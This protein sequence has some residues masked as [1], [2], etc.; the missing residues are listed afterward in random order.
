MDARVAV[1]FPAK[2]AV[3]DIFILGMRLHNKGHLERVSGWMRALDG[4]L[5]VLGQLASAERASL[6]KCWPV[7][8]EAANATQSL[9][10]L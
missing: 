4:K 8:A 1:P 6:P 3:A 9:K 7:G 10:A 2:T 5:Q